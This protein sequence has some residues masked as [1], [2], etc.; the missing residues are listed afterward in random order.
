MKTLVFLFSILFISLQ[1]TAQAIGDYSLLDAVTGRTVSV[2]S[3]LGTKG[4]VIIF[5]SLDCPFAGMYQGRIKALR[6]T[7][8]NEGIN[9]ILINPDSDNSPAAQEKLRRF[10]DQSGINT[11]YLIDEEQKLVKL[12]QIS[13]IPEAIILAPGADGLEVKYKGAID[14]NPQAVTSVSE[15]FLER[16]INQVLRGEV[17][18]PTQVRATGCNIR[19]F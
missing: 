18:T 15:R 12:F 4:M 7:F 2:N 14:N 13:K 3:K 8:Q 19:N 17:P 16:A 6:A 11:S 10:I 9:F 1:S 5:H